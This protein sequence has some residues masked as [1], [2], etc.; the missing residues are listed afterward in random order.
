MGAQ[1]IARVKGV[2]E[3]GSSSSPP[4]AVHPTTQQNISSQMPA[5]KAKPAGSVQGRSNPSVSPLPKPN[6]SSQMRNGTPSATTQPSRPSPTI[7]TQASRVNSQT[8][9]P[10][11]PLSNQQPPQLEPQRKATETVKRSNEPPKLSPGQ[12]VN[13]KPS[14]PELPGLHVTSQP[15]SLDSG[16]PLLEIQPLS[17]ERPMQPLSKPEMS[18]A[19]TVMLEPP[20]LDAEDPNDWGVEETISQISSLDPTLSMHVEAFRTHEIDGKALL[21]LST[22]MLMKYLGLKLGPALK[23]C[24]IID[25]L[26]GKKHLPIG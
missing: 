16:P 13:P 19:S 8:T 3:T 18:R 23:I 15:G 2:K 24:N 1:Q 22:T 7:A 14:R 10:A 25:K 9:A 6:P 26:K 17:P 21:L 5:L 20:C 11:L 12:L 4:K